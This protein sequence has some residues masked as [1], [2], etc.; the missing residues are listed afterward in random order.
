MLFS[1]TVAEIFQG[2]LKKCL[3]FEKFSNKKGK[4]ENWNGLLNNK[5]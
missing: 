4:N 1:A 5:K 3:S 2:F